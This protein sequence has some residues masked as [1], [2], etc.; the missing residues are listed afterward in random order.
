[1]KVR[2]RDWLVGKAKELLYND[3]S[4]DA[5][6]KAFKYL[7]AANEADEFFKT[8]GFYK[9][10]YATIGHPGCFESEGSEEV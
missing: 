9:C 2:N 7:N 10:G 6:A 1:M 5:V 4:P 8:H 3:T